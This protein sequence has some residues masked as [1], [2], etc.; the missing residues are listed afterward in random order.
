M[1]TSQSRHGTLPLLL[2]SW[3]HVPL[4]PPGSYNKAETA[5]GRNNARNDDSEEDVDN[6]ATIDEDDRQWPSIDELR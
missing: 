2:K 1:D 5:S 4:V 3:E 6:D